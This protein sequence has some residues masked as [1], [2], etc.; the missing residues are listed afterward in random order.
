MIQNSMRWLKPHIVTL[1]DAGCNV[2]WQLQVHDELIFRFS[3]DLWEVMDG[4]VME[5]LTEHHGLN[6]LGVPI[7]AKWHM[8]KNWA[9]LK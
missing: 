1:Q 8:A 4:L 9:G 2:K 3:Q 6:N 7:T 5:A